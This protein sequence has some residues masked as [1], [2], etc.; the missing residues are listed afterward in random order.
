MS[1]IQEGRDSSSSTYTCI[2][3]L[4]VVP[5][6]PYCAQ[7]GSPRETVALNT[8]EMIRSWWA[9][10][11]HDI[12]VFFSTSRDILLNPG[13]VVRSYWEGPRGRYYQPVNYYVFITSI[14]AFTTLTFSPEVDPAEIIQNNNEL[15]GINQLETLADSSAQTGEIQQGT[16][17]NQV[18]FMMWTRR[19]FNLMMMA[20]LPFFVLAFFLS[21]RKLGYTYGQQ[22]I[23]GLY[24]T[25]FS[26]LL[27]LP[28]FFFKDPLDSTDP[29]SLIGIGI[30]IVFYTWAFKSVYKFS[31][32][33]SFLKT[34]QIYLLFFSF[35]IVIGI[36]LG[37]VGFI[38]GYTLGKMGVLG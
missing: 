27:G 36:V 16:L 28:I 12:K 26:A 1:S 23:F 2:H 13:K 14:V 4:N 18:K 29:T 10:R 6:A 3:C 25:G 8:K 30:G 7:C 15:M 35:F 32:G 22:F 33:K 37:I 20:T 34:L 9:S 5:Y 38:V 21:F 17:D 31:L 19:H 24:I 11:L